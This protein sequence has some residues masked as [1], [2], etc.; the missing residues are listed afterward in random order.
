MSQAPSNYWFYRRKMDTAGLLKDRACTST[1]TH[2]YTHTHVCAITCMQD[3]GMNPQLSEAQLGCHDT[4]SPISSVGWEYW[5]PLRKLRWYQYPHPHMILGEGMS[6]DSPPHPG[7]AAA[8][9]RA[10]Y[11]C[12]ACSSS[13]VRRM[14]S[15]SSPEPVCYSASKHACLCMQIPKICM[16]VGW[17]LRLPTCMQILGLCMPHHAWAWPDS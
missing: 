15:S 2:T 7:A 8:G 13:W 14:E 17:R 6:Q 12:P 11:P 16:Q 10:G 9:Q 4:A 1:H 3:R 5:Y